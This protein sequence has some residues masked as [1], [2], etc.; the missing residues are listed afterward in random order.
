[1]KVLYVVLAAVL[2]AGIVLPSPAAAQ[3]DLSYNLTLRGDWFADTTPR[4]AIAGTF[5]GVAVDGRYTGG[6]WTMA[7]YGHPFAAGT[8]RCV[9][10]CTFS[11]LTLAGRALTYTFTS[12]VP[13]WDT[14][15]R[16]ATGNISGL[17][18]SNSDWSAAVGAWAQANDLSP[19]QQTRLIVDSRTGM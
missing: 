5:G 3:A 19:D 2:A 14:S 12:P 4:G 7:V 11:G 6:N 18:A 1:M 16:F 9:T 15:T 10:V 8:Y 13:T 17:F